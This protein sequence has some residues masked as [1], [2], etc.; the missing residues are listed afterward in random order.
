MGK[1]KE[2]KIIKNDS[3]KGVS[4]FEGDFGGTKGY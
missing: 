1:K 3:N 4:V 2:I